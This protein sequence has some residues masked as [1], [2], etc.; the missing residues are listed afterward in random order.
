MALLPISFDFFNKRKRLTKIEYEEVARVVSQFPTIADPE[1]DIQIIL[2]RKAGNSMEE[3]AK[4][5][6]IS[7]ARVSTILKRYTNYF[8]FAL[9]GNLTDEQL[10]KKVTTKVNSKKPTKSQGKTLP[11]SEP[12]SLKDLI[13]ED[14]EYTIHQIS[15]LTGLGTPRIH[16]LMHDGD[17]PR[18]IKKVH[19]K[20]PQTSYFLN[21]WDKEEVLIWCE[22][23]FDEL[24][25]LLVSR[26]SQNKD[27]VQLNTLLSAPF[28]EMNW[29]GNLSKYQ[30]KKEKL[31]A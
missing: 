22:L 17:F 5:Y 27:F 16:T 28:E 30:T 1:R 15:K 3:I 21:V 12:D 6:S 11:K 9:T 26:L 24:K 29:V 7:R 19:I 31:N 20:N 4:I 10:P 18:P 14:S 23:R 13:E 2:L 8:N 25:K